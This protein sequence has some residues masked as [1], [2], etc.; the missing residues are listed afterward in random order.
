MLRKFENAMRIARAQLDGTCPPYL[1]GP[2]YKAERDIV[3]FLRKKSVSKL[4]GA[5]GASGETKR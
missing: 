1:Y 5:D 4:G 3:E 2:L